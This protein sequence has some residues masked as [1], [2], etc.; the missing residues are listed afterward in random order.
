MPEH[1]G[2]SFEPGSDSGGSDAP[3]ARG[4]RYLDW[5]FPIANAATSAR[6]EYVFAIHSVD[7]SV[8]VLHETHITGAFAEK[9]WLDLLESVGFAAESVLEET[10]EARPPRSVFIGRRPS[11]TA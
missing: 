5:T 2:E 9:T 11:Q 8:E 1:T 7:G 10:T 4:I 3:D 6:T